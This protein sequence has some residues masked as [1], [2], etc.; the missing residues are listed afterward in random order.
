MR[1]CGGAGDR[2]CCNMNDKVCVREALQ[3]EG[4]RGAVCDSPRGPG[5]QR[6]SSSPHDTRTAHGH[7]AVPLLDGV[8]GA[9]R[10]CANRGT[11]AHGRPSGLYRRGPRRPARRAGAVGVCIDANGPH[12]RS[13]RSRSTRPAAAGAFRGSGAGTALARRRGRR[14]SAR[15]DGPR[16]AVAPRPATGALPRDGVSGGGRRHRRQ[17]AVAGTAFRPR[18]RGPVGQRVEP[19][20][21]RRPS[22]RPHGRSAVEMA[23][24]AAGA[25]RGS[26]AGTAFR[27]SPSRARRP[28]RRAGPSAEAVAPAPWPFRCRD[29]VSRRPAPSEAPARVRPSG[30]R[31]RG[32]VGSGVGG[33]VGP[34]DGTGV[35][36]GVGWRRRGGRHR[37]RQRRRARRRTLAGSGPPASASSRGRRRR[38]SER[39]PWRRERVE[40]RRQRRRPAASGWRRQRRRQRR[41]RRSGPASAA[42]SAAASGAASRPARQR[43]RQSERASA[44]RRQRRRGVGE[45]PS[46]RRRSASAE[47]RPASAAASAA[48]RAASAEPP[49]AAGEDAPLGLGVSRAA[50]ALEAEARRR[51][52]GF[53]PS[54]RAS[55]SAGSGGASAAIGR[56]RRGAPRASGMAVRRSRWPPGRWRSSRLPEQCGAASRDVWHVTHAARSQW[57]ARARRAERARAARSRA[58]W[59][60]PTAGRA[61]LNCSRGQSARELA[62]RTESAI[63]SRRSTSSAPKEQAA[64]RPPTIFLHNGTWVRVGRISRQARQRHPARSIMISRLSLAEF[65]FRLYSAA[66]Q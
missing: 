33:N 12:G 57:S 53:R 38:P 43:R 48:R 18:R 51:A 3:L 20:R 63:A 5:G 60:R 1:L 4:V 21:R 25:F 22:H 19:G 64:P 13:P 42:A 29:G 62:D 47:G 15:R 44:A 17:R 2:T 23:A 32:P 11:R 66:V 49:P 6:A 36:S 28:A 54:A 61:A 55:P 45:R 7:M 37:R 30:P 39:A 65:R 56:R 27:T 8:R 59:R 41:R 58:P 24:R 52:R 40:R 50:A 35:G 46:A 10:M 16:P 14:R 31:R 9:C 34:A 26:G